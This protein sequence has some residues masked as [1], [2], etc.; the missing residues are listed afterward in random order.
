MEMKEVGI[1]SK[2]YLYIKYVLIYFFVIYGLI[3]FY[4]KY[5]EQSK[6]EH[7]IDIIHH[8]LFGVY[9]AFLIFQFYNIFIKKDEIKKR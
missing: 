6:I 8:H 3:F 5:L 7:P 2:V 9:Y 1:K 4:V